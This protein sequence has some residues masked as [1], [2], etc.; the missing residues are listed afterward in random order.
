MLSEKPAGSRHLTAAVGG[1]LAALL[2]SAGM[3]L[4]RET[5]QVRSAPERL[6]EWLLLFVPP[7]AFEATLQ[8]FSVDAKRYA[9]AA[10]VVVSVGLMALV[11]YA[12]LR[13]GTSV[14]GLA[15]LGFGLWLVVMLV[16]MP[17]TSAG[18]FAADLLQGQAAAV[19]GYLAVC[20][21]FV[22]V[23]AAA[24]PWRRAPRPTPAAAAASPA[25]PAQSE[26]VSRRA[27]LG[28]LGATGVAYAGT[29][30]ASAFLP[31]ARDVATVVVVDPQSPLPSGGINSLQPH[32]SLLDDPEAAPTVAS[33][34][35]PAA[36][37]LPE[38]T[39]LRQLARDKDGALMASGRPP[40]ELASLTT[41]NDTF[42][43]VT[44]NA[45][46][47]PIIHPR[48]WR[49]LV[50]GEV[51]Q[52]FQLDY[53][54]LRKL[55]S[56][57]VTKTLEC[58]SNF[59][60][61]PE[62]APFGSEMISTAVWKGVRIAD[63]LQLVGGV[64][65]GADSV[66]V[67]ASDEYT[68]ALPLEAALDPGTLLVYE[69]NGQTLPREHGYPARL[70]VPGLYG[71]KSAKW[72]VGLRPLRREFIDWYGQRNWSKTAEV[73][74]MS[75]IDQPAPGA[76]L[77]AGQQRIAG[78]AYAG[79]RGI[80]QVEFSADAGETWQK[81]D[82]LEPPPGPDA[83]VRWQGSFTLAPGSRTRLIARATDGNGEVQVEP[84]SLP[85]PD[86]GTG[87]PSVEVQAS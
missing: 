4:L 40:G 68:S 18:V 59:V 83:W 35:T 13:R 63:I 34:P 31:G 86:G 79:L 49:L 54:T 85:Q 7:G 36:D 78:V 29:Y 3:L 38:P 62:L 41:P 80:Q 76:T 69:M 37:N 56:V 39:T 26:R 51:Q 2:A 72:V 43:I 22:A 60:G 47:D 20:L 61:K 32:P 52:P 77:P 21:T 81:A 87:W 55:P 46:G 6:M 50:D 44:K 27:A 64:K 57:E 70:L 42:Y 25:P 28:L 82:M 16:I 12:L 8:R 10:A 17:L 33:A 48:D 11:G 15:A 67:L 5:L 73:R 66:A 45:G 53:A 58:I 74:T 84:F 75:R 14:L 9:L 23:L 30:G 19:G 24:R 65:S 1:L 71:M